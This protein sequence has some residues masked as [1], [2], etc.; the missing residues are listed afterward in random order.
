MLN[1]NPEK[2][3]AALIYA[4]MK[5]YE[6]SEVISVCGKAKGNLL[7]TISMFIDYFIENHECLQIKKLDLFLNESDMNEDKQPWQTTVFPK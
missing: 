3:N 5:F 4:R 2:S 1:I 6:N 7:D